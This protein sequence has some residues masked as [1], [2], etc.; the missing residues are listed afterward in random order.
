MQGICFVKVLL[1]KYSLKKIS[2]KGV[3]IVKLVLKCNCIQVE[4]GYVK[5]LGLDLGTKSLGVAISDVTGTIASS[6][7][8]LYFGEEDYEEAIRKLIPIIETEVPE[9][10]ILGFPKNMNGTI[11]PRAETTRVF[12]KM[13]EDTFNIEVI[14]Q[15][16]RLST[17][18]ASSYMI[19]AD[20]S[21]KKRKKKIDA[22]AA[23]IILQ[24]YLDKRKD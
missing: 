14:L 5:C 3:Q 4:G 2:K 20:M 7:K 9:K 10:I 24:T 6:Y 11:G 12:K 19:E 21:R 15:D 23:N 8:T 1:A 22:L 16:E 17:K 18:E 13:L